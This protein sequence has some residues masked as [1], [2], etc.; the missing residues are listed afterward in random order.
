MLLEMAAEGEKT[1]TVANITINSDKKKRNLPSS[2]DVFIH[3]SSSV[4][5]EKGGRSVIG[6][7]R[8]D[9]TQRPLEADKEPA[10]V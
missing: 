9:G 5:R 1:S 8:S 10:G 3:S 7:S 4:G 2:V 6:C